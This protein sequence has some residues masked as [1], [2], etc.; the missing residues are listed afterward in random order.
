MCDR[1]DRMDSLKAAC[2]HRCNPQTWS[3]APS[4]PGSQR[5]LRSRVLHMD[6]V[7]NLC[8][9]SACMSADAMEI[10][11]ICL[12][13]GCLV[14]DLLKS[15]SVNRR[16]WHPA[17]DDGLHNI[18]FPLKRRFLPPGQFRRTGYLPLSGFRLRSA[19]GL[20]RGPSPSSCVI[21]DA[22]ALIKPSSRT[23]SSFV[24]SGNTVS[25]WPSTRTVFPPPVPFRIPTQLPYSSIW[26]SV[27]PS[28]LNIS[29]SLAA[30]FCSWFVGAGIS[31]Q[32]DLFVDHGILVLFHEL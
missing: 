25:M 23:I 29:R 32:L 17:P 28:S 18:A 20:L 5:S 11:L 26:Q 27:S 10:D 6:R 3:S 15:R 19:H 12:D 14:G 8:K 2:L 7:R 21:H 13:S 22:R 31:V 16:C 1:N 9:S 30:F 24:S 4:E